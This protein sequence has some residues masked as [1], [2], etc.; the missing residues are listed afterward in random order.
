MLNN[1]KYVIEPDWMFLY[2]TRQ[3]PSIYALFITEQGNSRI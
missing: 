1:G 2:E 3:K